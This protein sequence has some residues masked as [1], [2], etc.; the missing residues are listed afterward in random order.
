MYEHNIGPVAIVMDNFSGHDID[1][2][3]PKGQVEVIF[4]PANTTSVSQPLDQGIIS[5]LKAAYKRRLLEVMVQ[6]LEDYGRLQL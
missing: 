3:D 5:I 6:C 4:L 1:F 2:S